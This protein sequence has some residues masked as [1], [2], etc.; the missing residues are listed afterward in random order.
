VVYVYL[1][2]RSPF[3]LIICSDSSKQVVSDRP[4]E[5]LSRVDDR[6]ENPSYYYYDEQEVNAGAQL[7]WFSIWSLS[8]IRRFRK[9]SRC[10]RLLSTRITQ[11]MVRTSDEPGELVSSMLR[12]SSLILNVK[13][14]AN[15]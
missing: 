8:L 14:D 5:F 2:I 3:V 13:S 4:D 6:L 7:R 10:F 9:N 11:G 12:A 1:A 15:R